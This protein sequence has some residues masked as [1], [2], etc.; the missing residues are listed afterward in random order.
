[1]SV[2]P[3]VRPSV[4][5]SVPCYFR[6][7]II[8]VFKVEKTLDDIQ[9]NG[10]MSE[11]DVVASDVLPRYLFFPKLKSIDLLEK[12]RLMRKRTVTFLRIAKN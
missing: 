9:N 7:T 6:T 8:A 11:D 1:M 12:L 5:P 2:Y 3:S 4:R 10:K